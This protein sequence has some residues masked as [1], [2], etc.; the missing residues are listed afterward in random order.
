MDLLILFS[1]IIVHLF[2]PV[3]AIIVGRHISRRKMKLIIIHG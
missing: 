3:I 2:I 1:P